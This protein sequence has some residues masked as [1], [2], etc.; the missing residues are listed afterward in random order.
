MQ[1]QNNGKQELTKEELEILKLQ[2]KIKDLK[3]KQKERKRKERQKEQKARNHRLIKI[4]GML[5][6]MFETSTEEDARKELENALQ[7]KK[8]LGKMGIRNVNDL[9]NRLRGKNI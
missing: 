5:E 4:G 9:N 7:L 8:Y 1:E 2:E 6:S 3:E